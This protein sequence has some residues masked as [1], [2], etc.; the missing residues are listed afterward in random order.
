I[1]TKNFALITNDEWRQVLS[2]SQFNVLHEGG[3]EVAFTGKYVHET[4]PGTYVTA[5]CGVPVFRSEK[6]FDS[7]TGW[8]SFTEPMNSD[9]VLLRADKSFG[10]ERIE[11]VEK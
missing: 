5:D 11:V 7:G 9:L 10:L 3:T 1:N 6:K 2:P 8:P 4:R